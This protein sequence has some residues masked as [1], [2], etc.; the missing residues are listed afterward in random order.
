M[1][2]KRSVK[3]SSIK[4]WTSIE[5][6]AVE[7]LDRESGMARIESTPMRPEKLTDRLMKMLAKKGVEP[8]ED[9]I[10]CWNLK[11][12]KIKRLQIKR[13]ARK[14]GFR[15][16]EIGIIMENQVFWALFSKGEKKPDRVLHATRAARKESK[17]LYD[18][19]NGKGG[20]KP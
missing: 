5:R 10:S 8:G 18:S 19:A 7:R 14:I 17:K 11:K 16:E 3:S 20:I 15:D 2:S 1:K 13:L 12:V 6:W 9:K 4:K